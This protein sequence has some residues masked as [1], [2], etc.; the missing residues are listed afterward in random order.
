MSLSPNRRLAAIMFTDIAGYSTIMSEDETKA[1][2][3]L[4]KKDSIL[5]PL[6]SNHKGNLVKNIGDGSLSYFN[7][8]VDA[9]RCAKELQKSLKKDKEIVMAAVKKHGWAI[10]HSDESLH[11]DNDIIMA[12]LKQNPTVE[13]FLIDK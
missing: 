7:S 6:I 2:A 9:V 10:E 8:A 5:K 11:K 4:K 1:V 12:A 13:S 3:I